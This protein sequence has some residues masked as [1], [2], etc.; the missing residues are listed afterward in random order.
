VRGVLSN[1]ADRLRLQRSEIVFSLGEVL[2]T[3]VQPG[4]EATEIYVYSDGWENGSLGVSMYGKD[5]RPRVIDASVELDRLH[6]RM[7]PRQL[8][9]SGALNVTW[10]GLMV[11]DAAAGDRYYDVKAVRQLRDFWERLLISLGAGAVRID[12]I[13]MNQSEPQFTTRGR[14]AAVTQ[15]GWSRDSKQSSS[16]R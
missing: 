3:F 1:G 2:R 10:F 12:R 14:A 16:T 13:P 9:P 4:V 8:P 6:Q 5:G 11:E 7:Q 15:T